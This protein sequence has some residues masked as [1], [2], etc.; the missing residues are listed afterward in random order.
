MTWSIYSRQCFTCYDA[1]REREVLERESAIKQQE[2]QIHADSMTLR[3][4]QTELL[5]Q[6][7]TVIASLPR[8]EDRY[9]ANTSFFC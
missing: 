6:Y 2:L 7:N 4:L 3:Q 5:D 1:S 8:M 9:C